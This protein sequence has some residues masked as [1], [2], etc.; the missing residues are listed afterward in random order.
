M[1][2]FRSIARALTWLAPLGSSGHSRREARGSRRFTGR[3]CTAMREL[4]FRYLY[5]SIFFLLFESLDRFGLEFFIFFTSP[6]QKESLRSK[7]SRSTGNPCWFGRS[8]CARR[9]G[10]SE[11]KV[12]FTNDFNR[13][14]MGSRDNRTSHLSARE[15]PYPTESNNT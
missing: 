12:V 7:R 8:R 4:G 2:R 13:R 6:Q 14:D 10:V 5:S 9:F 1:G 3:C 11:R 15:P